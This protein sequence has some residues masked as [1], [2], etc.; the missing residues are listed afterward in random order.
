LLN[1]QSEIAA[2]NINAYESNQKN[3]R[4]LLNKPSEKTAKAIIFDFEQKINKESVNKPAETPAKTNALRPTSASSVKSTNLNSSISF[5]PSSAD[6]GNTTQY[7]NN[8]I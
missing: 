8:S 5:R 2:E 4:E 1:K 6:E 3:N 7:K